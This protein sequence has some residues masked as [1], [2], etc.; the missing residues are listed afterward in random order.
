[1]RTFTDW[2]EAKA[3]QE[4]SGDP[5]Q[6][7]GTYVDDHPVYFLMAAEASDDDIEAEAFEAKHGRRPTA[8]ERW[9]LEQVRN[10]VAQTDF[11]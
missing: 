3:A 6:V 5:T 1:M 4:A 11:S 10:S 2:D 8:Y 9:L 7:C